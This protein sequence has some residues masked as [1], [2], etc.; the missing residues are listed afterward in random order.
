MTGVIIGTILLLALFGGMG[1]A[2][3]YQ[4][5]KTDPK[6]AD[7]SAREDIQTA[8]EFLP[9]QDISDSMVNLGQHH[10][11]A[12][13]E[14]NSI[15]YD[16]KT[17]KEKEIIDLSFQRFLNSLSHPITMFVHTRTIDDEKT[18]KLL[19]EDIL[20]TIKDY[21]ELENYGN[22]YYSEMANLPNLIGNNKQ[23]KKYIIVP[24]MEANELTTATDKEKYEYSAKEM[25][26][27]CQMLIDGLAGLGVKG[28]I[29]KTNEVAEVIFGVYHRQNHSHVE[30]VL[31]GEYLE[32]MVEG[33]KN[34]LQEVLPEGKLDWILYES[35]IRLEKEL[36][37]NNGVDADIKSS[38]NEAILEIS[39]IREA[40]AGYYKTPSVDIPDIPEMGADRNVV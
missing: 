21:P 18:L 22:A 3:M 27:R 11:R 6:N 2:V 14:C 20:T 36:L 24:Y 5:K 28:H 17:E 4:L 7:T 1:W 12:I 38:A 16:L 15:N 10:Y 19:E 34:P 30:S 9:Y 13:I 32:L 40:V 35:Q 29:L 23:K 8:Q 39:R 25:Y 31:S 33:E 37:E 26:T